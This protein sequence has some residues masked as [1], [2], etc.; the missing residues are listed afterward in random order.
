MLIVTG[1]I[2]RMLTSSQRLSRAQAERVDLQSN[3]RSGA[4]IVPA[5]LRELSTYSGGTDDQND[6]VTTTLSANDIIYRAMR[7]IGFLCQTPTATEIRL[8]RDSYSGYRDPVQTRDGVY[9][10]MDGDPDDTADDSWLRLDVTAVSAGTCGADAAIILTVPSTPALTVVPVPPVGTPVR[11]YEKMQLKLYADA[12][13]KSWLGALSV[14][15]DA[16]SP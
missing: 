11:I 12:S 7:G 14:N 16:A 6:V 8:L 3:V 2:Y 4:L 15:T 13:G 1:A 10:F 9:V 5:E